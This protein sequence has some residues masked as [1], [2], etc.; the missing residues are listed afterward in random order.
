MPIYIY[1]YIYIYIQSA[2]PIPLISGLTKKRRY[3]ESNITYKTLIW[4]LEMGGGIG[5]D[6]NRHISC[7]RSSLQTYQVLKQLCAPFLKKALIGLNLKYLIT[8]MCNLEDFKIS[9]IFS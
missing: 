7:H 6:C 1:I 8:I 2:P 9:T 4:D 3:S 5:G